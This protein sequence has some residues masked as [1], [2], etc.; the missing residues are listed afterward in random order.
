MLMTVSSAHFL[1]KN[2]MRIVDL[3]LKEVHD[4]LSDRKMTLQMDGEAK[5]YLAA[6]GHACLWSASVEQGNS[7]RVA[8]PVVGHPPL[9]ARAGWRSHPRWL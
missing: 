8:E 7:D 6:R 1:E 2:I 5:D 4:R 9:R 3:R